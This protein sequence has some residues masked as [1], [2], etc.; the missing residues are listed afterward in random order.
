METSLNVLLGVDEGKSF[1]IEDFK[2]YTIGRSPKNDIVINDR[3]VSR[4]HL[5][6][7]SNNGLF[8]I[9][10]LNSRNGTF[11]DSKSIPPDNEAE[12]REGVP[13]VIGLSVLCLGEICESTIKPFLNV[14]DIFQEICE[15]GKDINTFGIMTI[16]KYLEFIHEMDKG[17]EESKDINDISNK[18]LDLT[19]NLLKRIDRC[20]IILTDEKTGEISNVIYRSKART[21]VIDP[22]QAYNPELVLKSLAL[23][24]PI[25]ISDPYNETDD[26]DD[27]RDIEITQSLQIMKIRSAMCIPISS[28]LRTR[29]ALYVDS[30]ERPNGFRR[31]DLA[32]LKEVSTRAALAMENIAL[33]DGR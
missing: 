9:N 28:H 21:P 13:I 2:R 16:K 10:D 23:N 1:E 15:G 11:I 19:F 4:H 29:G 33:N 5:S 22:T 26:E 7:T 25:L 3:N 14:V 24:K 12:T 17:F 30:L 27:G 8:I 18:I 32:L 6:I 20:F 31:N